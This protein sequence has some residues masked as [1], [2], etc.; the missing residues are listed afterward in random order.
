MTQVQAA[1]VPYTTI[2]PADDRFRANILRVSTTN[3][4]AWGTRTRSVDLPNQT[5]VIMSWGEG[6]D[7]SETLAQIDAVMGY[8][9]P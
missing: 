8:T 3:I 9:G 4:A 2:H 7:V 5:Y 6:I 1:P